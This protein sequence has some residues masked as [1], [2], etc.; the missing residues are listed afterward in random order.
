MT[1]IP[2]VLG[3]T[4]VAKSRVAFDLVVALD[5]EIVVADSRQVYRRLQIATHKPLPSALFT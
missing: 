4:A 2:V 1:G 3:P 5:R